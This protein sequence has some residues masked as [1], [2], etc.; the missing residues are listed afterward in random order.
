M[1]SKEQKKPL[2]EENST[3]SKYPTAPYNPPENRRN[4]SKEREEIKRR[5]GWYLK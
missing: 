2:Q 5:L 3:Q 1:D 4:N